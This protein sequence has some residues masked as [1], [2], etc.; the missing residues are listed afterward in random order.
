[1]P[2]KFKVLGFSI[3]AGLLLWV[4]GAAV[5]TWLFDYLYHP[6]S[7]VDLLILDVPLHE[8][9]VRL[10]GLVI[11][12]AFGGILASHIGRRKQVEQALRDSEE[13]YRGVFENAEVGLVR[14][15]ISDG[16]VLDANERLARDLG[17]DGSDQLIREFVTNDRYVDADVGDR[18]LADLKAEGR[19]ENFEARIRRK[20]DTVAWMQFSARIYPE[21]GYIEAVATDIT[22]RKEVESSLARERYF[23]H[24]LM[25]NIPD[26][27]Y[28]KDADSRFV[29]VNKA[30]ARAFGCADPAE[31]VG[32]TDFDFFTPEHA[33]PAYAD[34]QEVM[35]TGRP[36]V[37]KEEK[38][39]WPDGHVTWV[40]TTKVPLRD[41]EGRI[42]GTFG[43]S[44]NITER[45][46]AAEA[47]QENEQLLR[48]TLESTADGI[49]VVN[50]EGKATH[51]NARFAEM[52]RMPDELMQTRDDRKLIDYVL[53][54]LRDPRAF[55]S[56]IEELYQSS[57]EDLD[58]LLFKDGRIFERFSCPLIRDAQVAG[59]VWSFRDVTERNL[60]NEA[61][62]A[63]EE[64]YRA[65]FNAANDAIFVH[66]SQTGQIL[67]VNEKTC[68]LF[69]Y[70][71]D[72]L[73]RL[74]VE[75]ISS[76]EPPFTQAEAT[77]WIRQAA[78]GQPQL[79]EWMCKDAG[80]RVFWVEVNL[81][82][83]SIGGQDRIL[84]VVRDVSERK[85]LEEQFRQ[86]Q[87]ME[88]VGRLAGGVAHDFNNQMTVIKG[89]CD[90]LRQGLRPDD[91]SQEPLIEI[92][93][94]VHRATRVT[95]QLLAFSR[96]QLLHPQV[97]DLNEVLSEMLNPLARMIGEDIQL[98]IIPDAALGNV[99]ID[100]AQV[101]QAIINLVVN[102]RDAMP[103]G[104]RLHI[105]PANVELGESDVRDDP[106]AAPG[107][108]VMLAVSDTGEG[109][110]PETLE[111]IFEPF[112][113]TKEVGKGTGLGL[114][115]VYGFVKQSGGLIRVQS[116]DGGGTT[117]RM[118][119]PRVA[120]QVPA[121]EPA[122]PAEALPRGTETILVA[123]DEQAVRQLIVRVLRECGYTVLDTGNA[124][125]AMP[126]GEHYDGNIDLLVSDVIMPVMNGPQLARRLKPA[127]PEMEVLYISGY[128]QSDM[129]E[130]GLLTGEVNL[131][132]KPF[133]PDA[134]ARE[135]RRILDQGQPEGEAAG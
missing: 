36:L 17:Y 79:F 119:L 112:F 125:E 9:Y 43:I 116:E 33:E 97:I 44:R 63:S 29:R 92:S 98:S 71:H 35:R 34:E 23:L 82:K 6:R 115:M 106:D 19:V 70:T 133:A 11:V 127:R 94:A 83:A 78:Q 110:S 74:S 118:Y 21:R 76:G 105:E 123:E 58:T 32:K 38:E 122:P 111:R 59:R 50:A 102:A 104:G 126:L 68:E 73:R 96:K 84:A 128:P 108:Y 87:K 64:N 100:R 75:D 72:Q 4:A 93:K 89:Y 117:F 39:T 107:P 120:E 57:M 91:D 121:A 25:D 60:A 101:E 22:E 61:L 90:L 40:S 3:L 109:M 24:S 20:D 28:F 99:K 67:D 134:F 103:N 26:S 16:K 54:Q 5:D 124:R 53:D 30:I 65:I 14:T 7:F 27:I 47:L 56:R 85:L 10:V 42:T 48:A 86:A 130:Q 88:A 113:T 18:L 131:L 77:Q 37:G 52:W 45:K 69:G 95:S 132:V 41:A 1:M 8:I 46:R 51:A 62:K 15:R 49:L 55:T 12:V 114:S 135:V 129:I 13:K 80:G 31:A 2:V 66:H 81:K